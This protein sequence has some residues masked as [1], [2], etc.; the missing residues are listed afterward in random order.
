MST[1]NKH[2]NARGK[3]VECHATQRACRYKGADSHKDFPAPANFTS[4]E[5]VFAQID[6]SQASPVETADNVTEDEETGSKTYTISPSNMREALRRLEKANARLERAGLEGRYTWEE[7]ERIELDEED[8]NEYSVIDLTVNQPEIINNGWTFVGRID[9]QTDPDTGEV[10]YISK[11]IGDNQIGEDQASRGNVCDQCGQNRDRHKTYIVKNEEGEIKKVG[12]SCLKDF[13]TIRPQ[14]LWALESNPLDNATFQHDGSSRHSNRD[15]M[16]RPRNIIAIALALSDG[17]ESFV[18]SSSSG[19]RVP[20]RNLVS[21]YLYDPSRDRARREVPYE[22]YL[23]K[24]DE[25]MSNTTFDDGIDYG[26]NMNNL[27][28]REHVPASTLGY[29]VSSIAAHRRQHSL[30]QPRVIREKARGYIA[31]VNEAIPPG[32]EAKVEVVH[33]LPGYAYNSPDSLMIVMRTND[34]KVIKWTTASQAEDILALKKGTVISLDKG[35]VKEHAT[36]NDEDQTVI[37]NGK[38]RITSTELEE[39]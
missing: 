3:W 32:I 22:D 23:D 9:A 19:D 21:N 8:G 37:K 30:N 4:P 27:L 20:T 31:E 7:N 17:G 38:L 10:Y 1:V 2:R 25:I 26:R 39:K 5:E 28:R 14:G 35:K 18:P 36:F 12:S 24:A 15:M 29:L 34:N 16:V 13:L 11:S 33:A 6:A